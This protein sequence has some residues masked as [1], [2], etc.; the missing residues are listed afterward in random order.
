MFSFL[1]TSPFTGQEQPHNGWAASSLTGQSSSSW[2]NRDECVKI[3]VCHISHC[4]VWRN[5][6][7]ALKSIPVQSLHTSHCGGF[8]LYPDHSWIKQEE[9]EERLDVLH[10][11]IHTHALTFSPLI[12]PCGCLHP[13]RLFYMTFSNSCM[14]L[15]I[16]SSCWDKECMEL[17]WIPP[18]V[19]WNHLMDC[20]FSCVRLLT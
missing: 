10:I 15:I 8:S 6:S 2:Q 20:G 4:V 1:S 18:S 9:E 14:D 17:F 12:F 5:S 19:K 11:C 3:H 13:L 7:G 16:V